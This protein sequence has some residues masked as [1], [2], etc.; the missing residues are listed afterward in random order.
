M[1]GNIRDYPGLFSPIRTTCN[2]WRF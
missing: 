1:S 2:Q